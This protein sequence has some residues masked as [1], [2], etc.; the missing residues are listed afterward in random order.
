MPGLFR[1]KDKLTREHALEL[2]RSKASV[3]LACALVSN[4]AAGKNLKKMQAQAVVAQG[5]LD[6]TAERIN[7]DASSSLL[8]AISTRK[9]C[10]EEAIKNIHS[11]EVVVLDS[12]RNSKISEGL[13][14]DSSKD[15]IEKAMF[16]QA[17]TPIA[18]NPAHVSSRHKGDMIQY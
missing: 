6:F 14:S 9:A 4:I 11:K 13:F 12:L 5:L 10:R 15:I 16:C 18:Q 7:A 1:K 8:R 17:P 2:L 3:C